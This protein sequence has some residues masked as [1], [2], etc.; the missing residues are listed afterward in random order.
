[1]ASSSSA[2]AEATPPW[3]D[4]PRDITAAIL[5][6]LGAFEILTS[7]QNVCKSW[8]SV[9]QDPAL[10]RS[11]DMQ[12]PGDPWETQYNL[13]K[14]CC[15]A[16]DRSQGQLTDISIEYFG[17]DDLLL[18][19]S[20]RCTQLRC[21]ELVYSFGVT[22][23]GLAAAVKNFPMLEALHL[24]YTSIEAESIKAIG[25]SCPLLKSFKL[26]ARWYKEPHVICDLEALA[27]AETMPEL[28]DLQLFGNKMT[29]EGLQAI[30]DG[31]PNLEYLDLR[32]CFNVHFGEKLGRL[33]SQRIEDLRRPYD[34]TDDYEFDAEIYDC[35]SSDDVS[36]TGFS[37]M[38]TVS[39]D[40]DD[41]YLEFSDGS[42]PSSHD[43][44][45]DPYDI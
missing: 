32:Q 17:S 5:H 33:C 38:D 44:F 11:I 21:L 22:G 31:C 8:R 12:N 4:L 39:D 14:M 40:L 20:H 2:A 7:A 25:N 6:R 19:I 9:C 3:L 35:E 16:V 30:L 18:C 42:E 10:W 41:D 36:I 28:R 29:N 26:N 15:H 37:D 13:D 24:Y 23:D 1:M 45:E 34:P 27:I 43:S